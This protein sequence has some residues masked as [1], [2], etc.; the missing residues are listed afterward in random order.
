M[1]SF[2]LAA[3]ARVRPLRRQRQPML[4]QQCSV[5]YPCLTCVPGSGGR[6][7]QE[8]GSHPIATTLH[9]NF[10]LKVPPPGPTSPPP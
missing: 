7:P 5:G 8:A 9:H 4:W 10:I 2:T 3:A 1:Q 6:Q